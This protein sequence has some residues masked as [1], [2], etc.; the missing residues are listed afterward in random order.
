MYTKLQQ[1]FKYLNYRRKA[2]TRHGIHSPFV[3]ELITKVID[4]KVHYPAFDRVEEIR[5]RL[6]HNKNLL[7]VVDFGAAAGKAGYTTSFQRV[8]EIAARNSISPREGQLLHRLVKFMKP[9]IIIEMGTS[10]GVSSI[11]QVSAFPSTFFLGM[12]GCAA[13]AAIAE[14]NLRKFTGPQQY[15]MV[16]GNFTKM[17]PGV[18]EKLHKLDYAF[19]DGNHAYKPTM[20]Y[21]NELVALMHEGSVMVIHD[22]NWSKEMERAWDE[23]KNDARVTISVDL[24]RMGMIFFRKGLPKQ[25]FIIRF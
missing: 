3:F 20:H 24:F 19:I 17:L 9:E 23:I 12:E 5:K 6:L 11:Y 22:I 16:I 15:S 18:L 4:D 14:E 10:L 13:T 21:F 2:K 7:E 25:D 1:L 8:K